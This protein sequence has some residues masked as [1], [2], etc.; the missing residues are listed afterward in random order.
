MIWMTQSW[1]GWHACL[2]QAI[3]DAIQLE[4]S[5]FITYGPDDPQSGLPGHL[6]LTYECLQAYHDHII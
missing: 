6:L 2:A 1:H 3:D 5:P 4:E